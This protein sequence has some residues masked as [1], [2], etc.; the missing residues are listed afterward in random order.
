M[1]VSGRRSGPVAGAAGDTVAR[2]VVSLEFKKDP[3]FQ[4]VLARIAAKVATAK[5]VK[6]GIL[7]GAEYPKTYET[8]IEYRINEFRSVTSVAQVA[9]WNEFGTKYTEARPFMQTTITENSGRWGESLAYLAKVYDYDAYKMLTS[10]GEGIQGQIRATINGWSTPANRPLTVYIKGFN[11]P[12][13]DE[14]I[15]L[16]NISYE[17]VR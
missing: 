17:V 3:K 6:V 10:M 4:K 5:A 15:L 8:R 2:K 7:E 11:Q 16:R 1:A 9:F 12:L 14:G 13:R